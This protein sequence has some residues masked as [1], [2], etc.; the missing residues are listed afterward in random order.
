[1]GAG[2]LDDTGRQRRRTVLAGLADS[3]RTGHPDALLI[4]GANTLRRY[5]A[6]TQS[7]TARLNRADGS[8][9]DI[10]NS[11]VGLDSAG[12]IQLHHKGRLVIGVEN[13]PTW[14][15]DVLRFLVIDLGGNELTYN[16]R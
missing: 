10:F 9:Y 4:A 3:L 8:Y 13:T 15:F 12:R 1:M 14:V 11:A 16:I 6:G 2:T 5:E 7:R